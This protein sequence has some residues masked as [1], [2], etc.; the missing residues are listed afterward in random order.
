[1]AKEQHIQQ[2]HELEKHK[3]NVWEQ[4]NPN[5]ELLS[6]LC[7]NIHIS[8]IIFSCRET[9]RGLS[10]YFSDGMS[11]TSLLILC[12]ANLEQDRALQTKLI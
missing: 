2:K 1:M 10:R 7:G 4:R 8:D 5:T 3:K 6:V 11:V 12:N 9:C